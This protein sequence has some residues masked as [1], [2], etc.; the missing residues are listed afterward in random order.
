MGANMG[1]TGCPQRSR[2]LLARIDESAFLGR[3]VS[4]AVNRKQN[5]FT[6]IEL[7]V[8]IAIIAI[9]AAILF[10]VFARARENARKSTCQSNLKQLGL[11]MMQYTQDYDEMLPRLNIGPGLT[12]TLP[13]GATY[14][15]YMLWHTSIYPYLKNT[16]ILSCPSDTVKYA[17]NYTGGG[18]YGMNTYNAGRSLAVI[19]IPAESMFFAEAGGGDSYNLDGDTAG[20][21]EEMVGSATFT[22][23]PRHSEG[24]VSAFCDGH[25]KWM[26]RTKIPPFSINSKYWYGGYTGT[27]P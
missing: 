10:P 9:L 12:Y 8:V 1:S 3:G 5:G 21:N 19:E 2:P 25:V 27:N 15:G 7:L 13:N 22:S 26:P 14:T 16:G 20:A 23:V 6:L 18:S 17:G 24:L 11:A 4:I